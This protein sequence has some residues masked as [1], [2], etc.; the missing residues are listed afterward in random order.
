LF[1]TVETNLIKRGT[2]PAPKISIKYGWKGHEISNNF[3]Y[4]NLS[5][6]EIEFELKFKELV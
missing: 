5:R 2:Y 3:P 4:R 1:K 6:F